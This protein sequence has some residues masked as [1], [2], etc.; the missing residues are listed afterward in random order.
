MKEQRHRPCNFPARPVA[1]YKWCDVQMVVWCDVQM[2]K[3]PYRQ[4]HSLTL[5]YTHTIQ[6][7]RLKA[8]RQHKRLR[9]SVVLPEQPLR[10]IPVQ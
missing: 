9:P 7:S 4:Q 5:P 6:S 1:L 10:G 3:T 2:D 8:A